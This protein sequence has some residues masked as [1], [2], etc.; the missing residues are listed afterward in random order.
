MLYIRNKHNI[1]GQ[2]YLKNK[3]KNK[4]TGKKDQIYGYKR[5]ELWGRELD[6]GSQKVKTFSY[7]INGCDIIYNMINII[8][9][10]IYYI[11]KLFR[12]YSHHNKNHYI[13]LILYL[14][15]M[16]AIPTT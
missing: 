6:D 2:L 5:W 11:L 14:S 8:N 7:K 3:Q 4:F 15:E 16:V 9:N 13:S 1:A 12:E 10:A